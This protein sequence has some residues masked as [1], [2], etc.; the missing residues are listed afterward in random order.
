MTG[1][2]KE[3]QNFITKSINVITFGELSRNDNLKKD[4]TDILKTFKLL[5]IYIGILGL[6]ISF[7]LCNISYLSFLP[8]IDLINMPIIKLFIEYLLVYTYTNIIQTFIG[9]T[10][11]N[12]LPNYIKNDSVYLTLFVIYK[13]V[14]LLQISNITNLFFTILNKIPIVNE[15]PFN[16][17]SSIIKYIIIAV[18]FI[19]STI[20][21]T[22]IVFLNNFVAQTLIDKLSP[23]SWIVTGLKKTDE[24]SFLR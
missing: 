19:L 16:L 9:D 12:I 1:F 15:I 14:P 8:F 20:N 11:D 18:L 17:I 23:P 2:T 6:L 22:S 3:A 10:I 5:V 4:I 7:S 21:L 24:F 13:S